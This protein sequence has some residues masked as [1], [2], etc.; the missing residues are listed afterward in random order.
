MK[1]LDIAKCEDRSNLVAITPHPCNTVIIQ[2]IMN[3]IANSE[4]MIQFDVI[5]YQHYL[6]YV[7]Y[8]NCMIYADIPEYVVTLLS[9]ALGTR[10]FYYD[11]LV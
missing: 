11:E 9:I 2:P 5:K 4:I 3:Y 7:A 10:I 6:E 1:L 8:D